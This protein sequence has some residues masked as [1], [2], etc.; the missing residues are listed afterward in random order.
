MK[1]CDKCDYQSHFLFKVYVPFKGERW[2]CMTCVMGGG[3]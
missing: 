3:A 2:W 1:V